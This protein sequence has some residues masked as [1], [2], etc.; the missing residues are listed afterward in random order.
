MRTRCLLVLWIA[1]VGL[2]LVTEGARRKK[3]VIDDSTVCDTRR[4]GHMLRMDMVPIHANSGSVPLFR[5]HEDRCTVLPSTWERMNDCF[6]NKWLIEIAGSHGAVRSKVEFQTFLGNHRMEAYHNFSTEEEWSNYGNQWHHSTAYNFSDPKRPLLCR[7]LPDPD[8]HPESFMCSP[9][10]EVVDPTSGI[11]YHTFLYQKTLPK[12]IE[13]LGKIAPSKDVAKNLPE[14]H[15]QLGTDQWVQWCLD[16]LTNPEHWAMEACN[17]THLLLPERTEEA[18][19]KVQ[20][21]LFREILTILRDRFPTV[22]KVYQNTN[23]YMKNMIPHFPPAVLR[24]NNFPEIAWF[25]FWIDYNPEETGGEQTQDYHNYAKIMGARFHSIADD[26]CAANRD[27][28]KETS[29]KWLAFGPDCR[30]R[31]GD[32]YYKVHPCHMHTFDKP[33]ELLAL[34]GPLS[35]RKSPD[36]SRHLP[37]L[38]LKPGD[39]AYHY[40]LTFVS[41]LVLGVG[42][43]II[44]RDTPSIATNTEVDL[45]KSSAPRKLKALGAARFLASVHVVVGHLSN[46]VTKH[47]GRKLN[48]LPVFH[49][50]GWGF[51]WVPFFM[52]L[53]GFVLTYA[54][55]NSSHPDR[56][57]PVRDFVAKRLR[58]VYPLY[59]CAL[60]V[61]AGQR[62]ALA[63]DWSSFSLGSPFETVSLL[64][65]AQ[66]W[67]PSVVVGGIQAHCWFV[68][69]IVPY[70][71]LHQRVYH[72]LR[73][74]STKSLWLYA[75]LTSYVPVVALLV[76]PKL[77]GEPV[78]WYSAWDGSSMSSLRA[79][80]VAILKFHPVSYFH[81]Y[82]F[83]M[84]MAFLLRD[85]NSHSAIVQFVFQKGAVVGLVG[86]Y[87]VFFAS[88]WVTFP[89]Y[90]L[91]CRLGAL[92]PL[93]GL[94]LIG[95]AL[96]SDM[97]SRT[98]AHKWA[99]PLEN[100]SYPQYLFQFVAFFMWQ[101]SA[102]S[103]SFFVF[104]AALS[105]LGYYFVQSPL[106]SSS[107]PQHIQNRGWLGLVVMVCGL[108]YI[109]SENR[110]VIL[111]NRFEAEGP[112]E[113]GWDIRLALEVSPS[114]K[115]INPSVLWSP[116]RQEFYV[117]FRSHSRE[118]VRS[119]LP[120]RNPLVHGAE[121]GAD[122][123]EDTIWR[124][125]VVFARLD[126]ETFELL[127][128]TQSLP[129]APSHQDVRWK[130]CDN[131][132][133]A[134]NPTNQSLTRTLV[135]GAE[136]PRLLEVGS[137]LHITSTLYKPVPRDAP[138]D[139]DEACYIERRMMYRTM[140]LDSGTYSASSLLQ[141]PVYGN[142]T[143]QKNW[144]AFGF[145][146]EMYFVQN[147]HPFTIVKPAMSGEP[148]DA[149]EIQ[150]IQ[151]VDEFVKLAKQGIKI[152]GGANPMLLKKDSEGV[153]RSPHA[154][155]VG[156][157]SGSGQDVFVGLF[158]TLSER[159]MYDNFFYEFRFVEKKPDESTRWQ[160]TRISKRL[161]L[162]ES[163]DISAG[164]VRYPM[165]FA[166]GLTWSGKGV[167][168]SYGSSNVE[169]RLAFFSWDKFNTFFKGY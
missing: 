46:G 153:L 147:M 61:R 123:A 161:D 157:E 145:E 66:A 168:V 146:N 142:S 92:A 151:V 11:G 50:N 121:S 162:I 44:W 112:E 165:T 141:S 163:K 4:M 109:N 3:R 118:I 90:K 135:T 140:D 23:F 31:Y 59:L 13:A 134:I 34:S 166:S 74:A 86:L 139:V 150:S 72:F 124:S 45:L 6:A 47:A 148:E 85:F 127:P 51:S 104:L 88:A 68:S 36:S 48:A 42:A 94:Y 26:V 149:V 37:S 32:L 100:L 40:L 105:L 17:A 155:H 125:E 99:E 122:T 21:E 102:F 116:T 60:L 95:L 57:E 103:V 77:M 18:F 8:I 25:Q 9:R 108:T 164:D 7:R 89:A 111:E 20:V 24:E 87:G 126:P 107:Q 1:V 106:K 41:V 49:V 43:Y 158:H 82:V 52:M 78:T 97:V 28:F 80:L 54:R 120:E 12:V 130:T 75:L 39:S 81:I 117:A 2:C 167:Y 129:F 73:T 70:W 30:P 27:K 114:L 14:I 96:E 154:H 62:A 128:D 33:T 169:S 160:L 79:Y 35:V 63:G 91:T 113:N 119:S 138:E 76:L 19:L 144:M 110:E 136:D 22:R 5:V 56:I 152:H 15:V 71:A 115:A 98:F 137:K 38:T 67:F 84:V 58:G 159:G 64:L 156:S 83:G 55:L 143:V 53:S 29:E 10:D 93:Q 132:I 133:G 16:A 131:P 101:A 65:M 69:C